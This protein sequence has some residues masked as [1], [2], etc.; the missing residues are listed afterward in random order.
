MAAG[1]FSVPT[2]SNQP[3]EAFAPGSVARASLQAE[4][5]RQAGQV[6]EIPCVV[7]GERVFTGN[8]VD[9][10]MPCD[11][12]HVLAKVHLAGP[13]EVTRGVE[14][15]ETARR[16]WATLPW[17]QRAS[18]LLRAA[19][20]L[21]GPWRDRVNAATML[22]QAKTCHQAEIDSACELIDF[23]RFNAKYAEG[24]Y[25]EQP[26]CNSPGV[27]NRLEHRPLDGFV[28]A[29]TPFNFTSIA[30]NLPT[31]PAL[32]GNTAVW[33]PSLTSSLS[34]WVL[35]ELL[36]DAGLPPGVVNLVHGHGADVG[37]VVLERPELA[38]IHF[39]GSTG[40]FQHLWRATAQRL[41]HYRAYPRI[42][43]ETGGKDFIVAHPSAD[44]AAVAVAIARGAFEYQGQ[45]CSA[46][47]RMY[48]PRSLWPEVRDR[49]AAMV[50]EMKQ[51]DVRDF[52][53]FVAAVIDERAFTKHTSYLEL[54]RSTARTVVGGEAD[55]SVGWFVQPTLF[56]VDDPH[57]RLM[58]EEI[59][60]PI[61]TA[62]VYDDAKWAETLAL[63][64]S[65]SPYALTGAV[66][67]RD[68][69]AID[70]AITALR[71]AAGNFYINDKPTGAVVGQ[72]P[73]G[74]S[75]ASG[76]N[77]KAGSPLNLLRWVSQRTIKETFASPTDWRY[78]FLG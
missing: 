55:R 69:L 16:D 42:V 78:P 37:D 25:A 13:A 8:T 2:P 17:D 21:E 76:T 56:E 61:A 72:Q 75:R 5:D 65:T 77:D 44:P 31:A 57:H 9:V 1:I 62:F 73:F 40:T 33:K 3:V 66:F 54:G 12:G 45:K 53:N 27:W 63:V 29:I 43:G 59:F 22:G 47:S 70:Q 23:W 39:T 19:A 7:G 6:V 34:C 38:G 36:E 67:A 18:V 35:F 60:G 4:L 52:S 71:H 11:H 46:A 74:G 20:L 32:M 26:P 41:E 15:A 58:E 49:V 48:V 28:F 64:D 10:T 68:R 14:A 50:G 30:L 24:I 51:G